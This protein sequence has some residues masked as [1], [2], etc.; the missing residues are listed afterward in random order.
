MP[1]DFESRGLGNMRKGSTGFTLLELLIVV[2]IVGIMAAI[3]IPSYG[4]YVLRANRT[5]GKT[6]IM[7]IVGKQEGFYNDRK[8]YATA[9]NLLDTTY[10]A[11][12]V[13]LKRDGSV[14]TTSTTQ[15]IYTLALTGASATA[16]SV[17]A[18]PV[19]RQLKDTKCGTLTYTSAGVKSAS[20]TATDCWT[21]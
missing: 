13:Y 10:G 17:V 11:A 1:A 19:N 3:A 5:V 4:D 21:R 6:E 18:T 15:A 16:Y 2:T 12:T 14:Q 20:G 8:A 7:R 9:L